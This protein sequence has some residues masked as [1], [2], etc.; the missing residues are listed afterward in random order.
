MRVLLGLDPGGAGAYGWAVAEHSQTLPLALRLT[1]VA[2]NAEQAVEAALTAVGD[3]LVKGA[4]IDAP[5]FW[6]AAGDRVADRTVRTAICE[7]GAAGGTVQHVN[8]LQGACL[9]QGVLGGVLLRRRLPGLPMSES[10]PKAFL[11]LSGVANEALHPRD[12]VFASLSK[13][14]IGI[15]AGVADHERDAAIAALSAWAMD[16]RPP[17]WR[18]LLSL[19]KNPYL[20]LAPPLAYWM[21]GGEA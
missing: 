2:D 3:D 4:G 18:D 6:V 8:R 13:Y 10:H 12:V 21:L 20:P 11:W 9:V 19:E 15:P 14:F 17:D 1:G 16:V 7:R 5:L